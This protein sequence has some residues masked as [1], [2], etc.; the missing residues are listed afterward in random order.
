M[1]IAGDIALILVAA[2]VGGVIAQ[3]LGLPLILGYIL[4]GIFVGPYT[5][6]PTVGEIHDIELL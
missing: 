3:R 6:G 2:F 4:A 1:G 5:G